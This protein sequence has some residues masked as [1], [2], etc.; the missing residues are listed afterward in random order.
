MYVP[1]GKISDAASLL[2]DELG[3]ASNIKSR[4]TRQSVTSAIK[5]CQE[6]LKAL[7]NR[8]YAVFVGET[9]SGWISEAIE[10]PK[11][12]KGIIYR[13]GPAFSLDPLEGMVEKG[14]KYA[15]ICMDLSEVTLATLQ[16][17]STDILFE[18]ESQVPQKQSRG[19]QSAKRFEKNRQLA[20]IAWFKSSADKLNERLLGM[21][22]AGII[23]SGPGL[24]KND[25]TEGEHL[26]HELRK[27]II[28]V[29]DVGYTGFQGI[30]ETIQNAEDL[31]KETGLVK[32]RGLMRSFF[33][34]LSK[35]G[36]V[37]Y[38]RK[39]VEDALLKGKV[40]TL[41]ISAPDRMLENTASE[42]GTETNVISTEF[43]EG[44]QLRKVFGGVAAIL[45]Y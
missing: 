31:L 24:T 3:K 2:R 26:H 36:A 43:E 5:S 40:K 21:E 33:T 25:F 18:D 12:L 35:D 38:G 41:L 7:S 39:T 16:G 10:A 9:S 44:E 13:C 42:F 23:I 1:A 4:T 19:G 22:L 34:A 15:I 20:I 32:Q 11:P 30:K 17:T 29:V 14:P 45:R 27:K 37:I 6:Q 8:H 28:G